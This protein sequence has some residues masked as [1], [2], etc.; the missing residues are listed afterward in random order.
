VKNLNV[1]LLVALSL[2]ALVLGGCGGGNR[3]ISNRGGAV[4]SGELDL[5]D[6]PMRPEPK[7]YVIGQGDALDVLFLYNSDLNQI[8]LKVRPDGR[9]SLPY[10]GDVSVA[11]RPISALDS[12]LTARFSEI[13]VNPDITV[14]V[15]DYRPQV[16]YTMGEVANPGGYE[17]RT[18]MTLTNFLAL[19]G[20]PSKGGRRNEI[21][22]IRRVAPDHIVGIQI[23]LKELLGKKRF[24]KVRVKDLPFSLNALETFRLKNRLQLALDKLNPLAPGILLRASLE[25]AFQVVQDREELPDDVPLHHDLIDVAVAF[26]TLLEVL[27]LGN[28]AL[29]A[30]Q[31][32]R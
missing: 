8:D 11:G 29:P 22:V 6:I 26:E 32:F 18:G 24:V 31:V 7:E 2:L 5:S 13:I 17:Y 23:D 10:V 4:E 15:R 14:I 9:I 3:F 12:L 28:R 27:K 25:G 21:L 1:K 19:S 16:V 30:I 20:G